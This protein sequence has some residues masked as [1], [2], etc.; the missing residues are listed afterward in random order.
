MA[1]KKQK[2]YKG[3]TIE[4]SYHRVWGI[5]VKK[6][7]ISFGVSVHASPEDEMITSESYE[8]DY[9]IDGENPF[10]Q[11]Y[12]HIKLLPEYSDAIDC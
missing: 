8:C 3:I 10:K 1:L 12:L 5:N 9:D 2:T 4:N 7:S 6:K 11:A